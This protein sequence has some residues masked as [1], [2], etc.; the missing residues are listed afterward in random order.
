MIVF[1][2]SYKVPVI[3]I[4]KEIIGSIYHKVESLFN[5]MSYLGPHRSVRGTRM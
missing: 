2:N 4:T 5:N 3:C 1:W